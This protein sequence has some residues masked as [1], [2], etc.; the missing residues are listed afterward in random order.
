M[1]C[2]YNVVLTLCNEEP[3]ISHTTEI[4]AVVF[5]DIAALRLAV[6]D[7]QKAGVKCKLLEQATPRAYFSNQAGMGKADY[8]LELSDS[9]YDVGFYPHSSG[10]GYTARTDL[11]M[12]SVCNILGAKATDKESPGQAALGRLNQAYALHA[13]VRQ[14]TLQG[15]K[16]G[17]S[18]AT[19]G[20]IKLTLT[21]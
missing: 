6:K 20:T 17:R 15:Y 10:K 16:V 11:F 8:V 14:A 13:T 3:K 7:L 5:N 9:P 2:G 18:A 12:G 21:I 19:D 1:S 4:E